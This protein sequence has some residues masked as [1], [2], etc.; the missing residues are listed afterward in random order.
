MSTV[1]DRWK[2]L[3][4]IPAPGL[5]AAMLGASGVVTQTILLRECLSVFAGNELIIGILLANWMILTGAGALLGRLTRRLRVPSGAFLTG[6]LL[7]AALPLGTV[8]LLHALRNVLFDPGTLIGLSETILSSFLLLLPYCVIAGFLFTLAVRT[9]QEQSAKALVPTVYGIEAVGSVV[10]GMVFNL[11][12]LTVLSTYQT[13][14]ILTGL[15]M[16]VCL[17]MAIRLGSRRAI[18]ITLFALAALGSLGITVGLDRWSRAML[19]PGQKIVA[20][21]DTPYGK[22]TVTRQ[23]DQQ[24]FFENGILLFSTGDVSTAEEAVH[25]AMVQHPSPKRV[26]LVSGGISGTLQEILKYHV[27]AIDYVEINPGITRL[28]RRLT[29]ALD[30]PRVHVINEDARR[31]V[32]TTSDRYDV[33]LIDVP[34]PSTAGLNRYYTAEFLQDLKQKLEPGAVVSLGS[35]PAADYYAEDAR[36]VASIILGTAGHVFRHTLIVPGLKIFLLASD[37]ELSLD[38][39]RKIAEAGISTTYVNRFYIDDNLLRQRSEDLSTGLEHKVPLNRDFVPVAYYRHL[40]YW[41]GYFEHPSYALALLAA[42]FVLLAWRLNTVTVGMLVGGFAGSSLE[43]LLLM[44]FQVLYGYVYQIVGLVVTSFMGGLA[45]GV[46]VARRINVREPIHRFAILQLGVAVFCLLLPPVLAGFRLLSLGGT[47]VT[48]GFLVLMFGLA[49]LVGGIFTTASSLYCQPAVRIAADLY[50]VDLA[51][52][53]V[54][55]FATGVILVPLFGI[56]WTSVLIG[57]AALTGA[58]IAWMRRRAY[59]VAPL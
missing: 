13:L 45:A 14:L 7:L 55:A 36:R 39:T 44:A 56:A 31:F 18:F 48:V 54:G 34:E 42:L 11:A 2:R 40:L 24:N 5:G 50:S 30:D 35:L 25:Y 9:M 57:A 12:L 47:I 16:I 41:L 38:I 22:L 15:N 27:E 21:A 37:R 26:L 46:F 33:A 17:V 10:G 6:L 51:G 23:G 49:M 3:R 53:G 43:V 8:F 58:S 4:E 28:G 29:S 20:F 19:Y 1:V 59:A 32:R 52:S